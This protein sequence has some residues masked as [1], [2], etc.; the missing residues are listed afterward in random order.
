MTPKKNILEKCKQYTIKEICT[1]GCYQLFVRI[2]PLWIGRMLFRLQS[3]FWDI[4]CGKNVKV[5]GRVNVIKHPGS[6]VKIG[7]NVSIVS[8]SQRAG[9]CSLYSHVKLRTFMKSAKIVINDNV[10]INGT[11]ISVRSKKVEI[12]EGTMIAPNVV[13][14]DSDFH[15]PW[16]PETRLTS[17]GYENDKDV[18]IGKNVWIGM[19]AIILKG[20]HLGDNSIIGAGSV[21]TNDFP[22]N[23]VIAGNP[24][25]LI[26]KLA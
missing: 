23:S 18:I 24:A 4:S 6:F 26:R 15:S 20:V 9:A 13:I 8:S 14:V 25:K 11:S 2:A 16:P 10:G 19:N 5:W 22:P 7:N 1:Y 12:G 17:P 3:A 21:V